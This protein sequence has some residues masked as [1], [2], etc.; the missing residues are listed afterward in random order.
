M[1]NFAHSIDYRCQFPLLLKPWSLL[2]I[3]NWH[4]YCQLTHSFVSFSKSLPQPVNPTC[5][6]CPLTLRRPWCS[7]YEEKI[8]LYHNFWLSLQVMVWCQ[9]ILL[10]PFFVAFDAIGPFVL[11]KHGWTHILCGLILIWRP[12]RLNRFWPRKLV[13]WKKRYSVSG[14]VFL[15]QLW[16]PW[17]SIW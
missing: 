15:F 16:P 2:K 11:C 5:L 10:Y 7:R 13:V 14:F 17:Q 6:S 4:L 3:Y 8:L 12:I 9:S 1:D